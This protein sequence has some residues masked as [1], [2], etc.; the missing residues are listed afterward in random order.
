FCHKDL[1][2]KGAKSTSA[3]QRIKLICD[4]RHASLDVHYSYSEFLTA[5]R[6]TE[7]RLMKPQFMIDVYFMIL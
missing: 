5:F 6:I 3:I 1:F 2:R 4:E 7:M